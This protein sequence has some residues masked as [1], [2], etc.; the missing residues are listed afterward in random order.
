MKP[1]PPFNDQPKASILKKSESS[2]HISRPL[3]NNDTLKEANR[4][5]LVDSK[6]SLQ[7]TIRE[8]L[9]RMKKQD[10]G[11]ISYKELGHRLIE[12]IKDF[13]DDNSVLSRIIIEFLE[14]L[15]AESTPKI[16]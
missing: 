5:Q 16:I 10:Q 12:E 2:K 11:Q 3:F 9:R 15:N 4:P 6:E 8:E 13:S 7:T 1:K 14:S